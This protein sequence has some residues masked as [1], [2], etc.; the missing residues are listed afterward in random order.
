MI[1]RSV[2]CPNCGR[3]MCFEYRIEVAKCQLWRIMSEGCGIV[4]DRIVADCF[5]RTSQR[6][7]ELKLQRDEAEMK[8]R[9]A[10]R[11]LARHH[12]QQAKTDEPFRD[13]ARIE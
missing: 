2:T 13:G 7:R 8:A 3:P 5:A 4:D 9:S 11:A 10:Q 6:I 12:E 1:D